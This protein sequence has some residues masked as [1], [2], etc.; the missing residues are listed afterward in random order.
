MNNKS[1]SKKFR[2]LSIAALVTG[3]LGVCLTLI[4]Q[5]L[6]DI[7]YESMPLLQKAGDI[8]FTIIWGVI[9]V[10]S[11][12]AIVCGSVDLKRIQAGRYNKK[13]RGFD[14][15]GIVLGVIFFIA[16]PTLLALS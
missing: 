16:I 4:F 11:V 7:M 5:L 12:T 14:I 9:F 1:K 10:L 3:L 13:G 15:A 6:G 2:R 8:L